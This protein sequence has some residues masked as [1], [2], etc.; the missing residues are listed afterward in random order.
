MRNAWLS[1]LAALALS[2]A[3][4][5]PALAAGDDDDNAGDDDDS[6]EES[7]DGPTSGCESRGGGAV[8]AVLP[9]IAAPLRRRADRHNPTFPDVAR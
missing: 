1:L 8:F 5:A 7:E 6:A 4:I 9:L 3:L 2:G